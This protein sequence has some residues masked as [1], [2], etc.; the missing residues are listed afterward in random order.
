MDWL[1]VMCCKHQIG[2]IGLPSSWRVQLVWLLE[3]PVCL[4]ETP[5]WFAVA[6]SFDW[7]SL[8]WD[9]H[10]TPFDCIAFDCLR[11]YWISVQIQFHLEAP[12]SVSLETLE[13]W[14]SIVDNR[15]VQDCSGS[16]RIVQI[17]FRLVANFGR[18]GLC[19]IQALLNDFTE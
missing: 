2:W 9:S 12:A 4:F 6:G 1:C 5:D 7:L 16:F 13:R 10:L 19:N 8:K 14:T 17:S 15:I 18:A 11:F 3:V